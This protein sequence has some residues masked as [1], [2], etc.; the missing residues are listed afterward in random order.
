VEE[1][2]QKTKNQEELERKEEEE[3]LAVLQRLQSKSKFQS[4]FTSMVK[5]TPASAFRWK[6]EQCSKMKWLSWW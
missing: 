4:F 5:N 3:M 1:E 6:W 2:R